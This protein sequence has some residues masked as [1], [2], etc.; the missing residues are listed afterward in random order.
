SHPASRLGGQAVV[1]KAT[2]GTAGIAGVG[3]REMA[4]SG[5][6]LPERLSR[7]GPDRRARRPC[8][9]HR[10]HRLKTPG[11][12]QSDASL[13]NPARSSERRLAKRGTCMSRMKGSVASVAV[14][15]VLV[16]FAGGRPAPVQSQTGPRKLDLAHIIAPPESGA[17]GFKYL[18]E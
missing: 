2:K 14:A 16:L 17:I 6:P 15:V 12:R 9:A 1:S 4:D 18:A 10:G 8:P 11:P 3:N 13:D 7:D 5:A